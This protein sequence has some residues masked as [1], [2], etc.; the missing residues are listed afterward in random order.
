MFSMLLLADRLRCALSSAAVVALDS[1]R[2][3]EPSGSGSLAFFEDVGDGADDDAV[4]D[5]DSVTDGLTDVGDVIG[6][7]VDPIVEVAEDEVT[8]D[9]VTDEEGVDEQPATR[10]ATALT[11]VR[12]VGSLR[13]PAIVV[14]ASRAGQAHLCHRELNA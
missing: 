5:D 9:E 14:G 6:A 10:A 7:V 3:A 1:L 2:I 12:T 8:E 11:T 4:G 13:M